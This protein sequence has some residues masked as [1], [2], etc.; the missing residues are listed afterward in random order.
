LYLSEY[1]INSQLL[2]TLNNT[3][4]NLTTNSNNNNI[5]N[6]N[7]NT[8]DNIT[9]NT[10]EMI[11]IKKYITELEVKLNGLLDGEHATYDVSQALLLGIYLFI[12]QCYYLSNITINLTT[13]SI[14]SFP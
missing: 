14:S 13:L 12:Y 1:S 8:N 2:N 4:A 9:N 10:N 5:I 3:N 11:T 7:D 6:N